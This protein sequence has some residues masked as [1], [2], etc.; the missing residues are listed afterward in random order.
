MRLEFSFRPL[1]LVQLQ[2][3]CWR[4]SLLSII[5]L[6]SM[7]LKMSDR[8]TGWMCLE[9]FIASM[10]ACGKPSIHCHWTEPGL[11]LGDSKLM[12]NLGVPKRGHHHHPSTLERIWRS[13]KWHA[14]LVAALYNFLYVRLWIMNPII[15]GHSSSQKTFFT[16]NFYFQIFFIFNATIQLHLFK[17]LPLLPLNYVL[18]A[19]STTP[20][21]LVLFCGYLLS[22]AATFI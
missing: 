5:E 2:P 11:A 13:T 10:V 8:S 22:H 6:L 21:Y 9:D 4:I 18:L 14:F 19:R 12:V 15:K 1:S 7:P 17:S 20:D 3:D 16:T